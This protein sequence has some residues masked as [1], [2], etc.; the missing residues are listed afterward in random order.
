MTRR[1]GQLIGLDPTRL[2]EYRRYHK[3]IWPEIATAIGKAGICNYSIFYRQGQ[4]FGY[5]EYDGPE[6]EFE[7]RM[8]G[9]ASAP[10]MREWWDLMGP[11]Q[12][13]LED[14]KEGQWWTDMEEIFHLD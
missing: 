3:E 11:M 4:L 7:E 10:R 14:R 8:A 2:D 13:P 5:F 9:I 6:D 1:F 12:K